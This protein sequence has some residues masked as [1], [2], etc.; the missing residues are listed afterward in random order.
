MAICS[1]LSQCLLQQNNNAHTVTSTAYIS[2]KVASSCRCSC[3]ICW[4]CCCCCCCCL[5][6]LAWVRMWDFKLVD[7]ANLLLQES[8]GQTYGRSPVWMRTW[9]LR[10]KSSE[11]LLP[12]PSNVHCNKN[13]STWMIW[14]IKHKKREFY[15][16]GKFY[17]KSNHV[18][19]PEMVFLLCEPTG[20]V[21]TSSFQRKPKSSKKKLQMKLQMHI[22]KKWTV[23]WNM[24]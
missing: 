2:S 6:P 13:K 1:S 24:Q 20:V 18:D 5:F 4:S 15:L 10:L 8:N 21:S 3:C 19:L 17:L 14:H 11:N 16:V 22:P 9:V 7:C 12:Q 23:L